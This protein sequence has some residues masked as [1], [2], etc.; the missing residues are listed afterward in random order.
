MRVIGKRD[1]ER[2]MTRHANAAMPLKCW[3]QKVEQSEWKTPAAI[4][5]Y[6]A[7]ASFLSGNRVAFNIGGNN[8]RLVVIAVC[9]QGML[10]VDWIGT[11]AE[12]DKKRS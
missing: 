7:S 1:I 8:F 3:V 5:A 4:K 12:Y 9:V 2:Y 6:F 11:R 10:V